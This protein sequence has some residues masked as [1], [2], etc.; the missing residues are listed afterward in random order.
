MSNQSN[1]FTDKIKDLYVA[2]LKSMTD[3]ERMEIFSNF[4][5]YCGSDNPKCQCW[6][7]E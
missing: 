7:D 1:L 2:I 3:E 6:K 5:K 4:C